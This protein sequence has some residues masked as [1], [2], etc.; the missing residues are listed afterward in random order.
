MYNIMGEDVSAELKARNT[1]GV[2][3][4]GLVV[5]SGSGDEVLYERLLDVETVSQVVKFC[6]EEGVSLIAYSGDDIV[7]VRQATI[8]VSYVYLMK[9]GSMAWDLEL[10]NEHFYSS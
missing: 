3:T 10:S 5:Y 1:P 2:F 7:S 6:E 4:Q 9:R 8:Y